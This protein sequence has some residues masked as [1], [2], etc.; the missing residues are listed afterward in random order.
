LLER[1]ASRHDDVAFAT[2]VERHGAMVLGVCRRVLHHLHDAEGAFQATFLILAPQAGAIRPHD[3][4]AGWLY[5][6]AYP[7][8]VKARAS[9]AK[10][11]S[12]L[13]REVDMPTADPLAELNGQELRSLLDEELNQLPEQCRSALV[14]C[15]LEGKT[16]DEAARLLGWSKGTLRRRLGQ[17]RELLRI[18][19]GRRG[20]PLAAGRIAARLPTAR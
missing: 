13:R 14:L 2:L 11:R 16:Q 6:V 12:Y 3:S 5:Q 17:G 8:A 15:Y 19:L 18:R 10:R 7:L 4:I 9:A 1:F 20:L